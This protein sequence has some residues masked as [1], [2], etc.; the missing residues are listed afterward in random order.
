VQVEAGDILAV[1]QG[2]GAG[3]GDPLERDPELVALDVKNGYVS[4]EQAA[5]AYGVVLRADYRPDFD[6]TRTLRTRRREARS[7]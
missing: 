6:A 4:V 3:Y 5:R 2:G 1:T 7:Q